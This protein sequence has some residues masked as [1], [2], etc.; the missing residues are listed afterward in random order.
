ML[1]ILSQR[2]H[3]S[4]NDLVVDENG[5]IEVYFCQRTNCSNI[6]DQFLKQ[7][8]NPLC[9]FYDI[10]DTSILNTLVKNKVPVKIYDKNY[11]SHIIKKNL[12]KNQTNHSTIKPVR[13]RGLMH[14]KFCAGNNYILTGSWNPTERGTYK[15]DNYLLLIKSKY[16]ANNYRQAYYSIDNNTRPKPLTVNLSGIL[17]KN[18][19]CPENNCESNVLKE[20]SS[21]NKSIKIL[22]F[23]FTSKSL[24]EKLK[25]KSD[26]V[27]I[28]ILFEK[29]RITRYSAYNKL[30]KFSITLKTDKN[31]YVMHEKIVLIDDKIVIVGSYNPTRSADTKNEENILI[32]KDENISKIFLEEINHLM[33]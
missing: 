14:N 4:Q 24:I 6:L 30:K 27:N 1:I 10:D 16:L 15:N 23:T 3:A 22:A 28:S 5:T 9:A 31:P 17:I 19:F 7:T 2:N 25:Q 26:Q 29:S 11:W 20:I 32:I 13:S 33:N 21:A 8:K 12:L 18:Y